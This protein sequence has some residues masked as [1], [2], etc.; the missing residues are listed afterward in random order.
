MCESEFDRALR[1]VENFCKAD[2]YDIYARNFKYIDEYEIS[3]KKSHKI[4]NFEEKI[5]CL[6]IYSKGVEG[7]NKA[8][9]SGFK[10]GVK[11]YE[12]LFDNMVR[13]VLDTDIVVI[14]DINL[15]ELQCEIK[16]IYSLGDV[17]CV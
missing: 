2:E 10:D 1:E 3:N 6:S 9:K 11:S 15:K 5:K 8:I 4:D 12:I 7:W 14:A 16:N 13:V 17:R